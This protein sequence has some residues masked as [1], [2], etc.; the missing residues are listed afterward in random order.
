MV[1]AG[2]GA[3][4]LLEGPLTAFFASRQCPGAAIRATTA[5][6]L[7]QAQA[8]CVLIGGFHSPLE[9]SVLRILLEAGGSAAVVL[10]RPVA[11]AALAASWHDALQDGKLA[12]VS[13]QK[14]AKRLT[15]QAAHDRNDIA[16]GLAT[17]IVIGHASPGGTLDRQ[18]ADWLAKGSE[19]RWLDTNY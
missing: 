6:A 14:R 16:A 13:C 11:G 19:V 15:Q 4:G 18:C 2:V 1:L 12:V 10:A 7:Q 9:Q 5:W 3:A 17:L 8:H